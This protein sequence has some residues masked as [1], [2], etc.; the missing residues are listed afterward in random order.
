MTFVMPDF[1]LCR[2]LV[3]LN[4]FHISTLL[5]STDKLAAFHKHDAATA[6]AF[7]LGRFLPYHK[8]TVRNCLTAII[9]PSLFRLSDDDLLAAFRAGDTYLF[10]QGIF[11]ED[12]T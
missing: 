4:L 3:F 6:L 9:F 10:T 5:V 7:L 2:F 8:I 11:R 1:L 12:H